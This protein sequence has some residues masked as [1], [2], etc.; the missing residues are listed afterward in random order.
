M[1]PSQNLLLV[2]CLVLCSKCANFGCALPA[3]EHPR[4]LNASNASKFGSVPLR[5][6]FVHLLTQSRSGMLNATLHSL[7]AAAMQH[8]AA[9]GLPAFE[10]VNVD[11]HID[12][13]SSGPAV[14]DAVRAMLRAHRAMWRR[15]AFAVH[16]AHAHSQM[17]ATGSGARVQR[18]KPNGI[19]HQWASI[20]PPATPGSA[21]LI[22]EDDVLLSPHAL[23]G[24]KAMWSSV[25][26]ARTHAL[27]RIGGTGE[28]FM[29]DSAGVS[30][31][32]LGYN[33][34]TGAPF[35][36]AYC[37]RYQRA[38]PRAALGQGPSS[39]HAGR[40]DNIND[41]EIHVQLLVSPVVSTWAFSPDPQVWA[42]FRA[43]LEKQR[44]VTFDQSTHAHGNGGSP[45]TPVPT[46]RSQ[47]QRHTH[48]HA[49]AQPHSPRAPHT[50]AGAGEH[51]T[52]HGP[53]GVRGHA[54]PNEGRAHHGVNVPAVL[55]VVRLAQRRV[56][57]IRRHRAQQH[58]Q[59]GSCP[60]QRGPDQSLAWA[61]QDIERGSGRQIWS[62]VFHAFSILN[63]PR[64]RPPLK[65]D[66]STTQGGEHWKTPPCRPLWQYSTVYPCISQAMDGP[67][68]PSL[69]KRGQ[70]TRA[71][72]LLAL[73]TRAAGV[74]HGAATDRSS[75]IA[76]LGIT[77]E[78]SLHGWPRGSVDMQAIPAL[79]ALGGGNATGWRQLNWAGQ[80]WP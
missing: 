7:Q 69:R 31:H 23:C 24:L 39:Q 68:R 54:G 80:L 32:T 51:P 25:G 61:V 60:P 16:G 13:S 70:A 11:V 29:A 15:G 28:A 37:Q 43:W 5:Q 38:P 56:T 44:I 27:Q 77:A 1:R 40:H 58:M 8:C 9:F 3:Q 75:S 74:H 59:G 71:P 18:F 76:D 50:A 55:R 46:G 33:A 62:A 42:A 22:L 26:H 63:V 12:F 64:G 6:V 45:N 17:L 4:P 57:Q 47:G 48:V 66:T 79:G 65:A 14:T 49:P 67:T 41:P 78:Q 36:P 30:L 73:H 52:A 2:A 19:L 20:A 10:H 35:G 34:V 53:T 21:M 72:L